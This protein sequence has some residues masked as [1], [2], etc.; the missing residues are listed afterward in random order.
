MRRRYAL[1][2]AVVMVALG[3][4][5]GATGV[6][7]ASTFSDVPA[8]YIFHDD[9][10]RL[11]DLD[12]I[13]GFPDGTFKP[14]DPVTRQQFAKMIV[15]ST[16]KH[17][18]AVDN[19]TDP[20]FSD[21][22]PGMGV[23]YP[24]DYIE[25]A[26]G[27]EYIFGNLGAFN[28]ADNITRA[29]LAL[30][31]VRAGGDALAT[32]PADYE[33]GFTDLPEFAADAIATAKFNG[34][35]DGKTTTTFDPYGNGT[36]GQ[37]C[38]MLSRLL[39]KIGE[40]GLPQ[41]YKDANVLAGGAAYNQWWTTDAAGSGT[42]PTTT[43]E[44]D[45]YRC[46][47]CHAWD[48][49]GNAASY[50]NRTGKSTGTASRPDVAAVDLWASAATKTPQELFDLVK[51]VG[52]RAIDERENSHPDFSTNATDAQIW[53][54]VKFLRE[55]AIDPDLLYD[56][57][58]TG[59]PVYTDT[60]VDPPVVVKPTLVYSNI[61]ALGN[62]ANGQA[63]YAAKCASCHGVDGTTISLEDMSLGKFLRSKPN[64]TWFKIKF[65]NP[66]TG[67]NPGLVHATSDL[68]DLYRALANTTTFPDL[69]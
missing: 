8:D 41:A 45:Y 15:L 49:K 60:S 40:P 9:I 33:T 6:L 30:I 43:A 48:L 14:G 10:V 19:Q 12:I 50:A 5:M 36:R 42:Q 2:A 57:M 52:G 51:G 55:G 39:D 46:K 24:F 31:I 44:A 16:D 56:L 67:M 62:E 18:D 32:P 61:G 53:N 28:P 27:A 21:V 37:V 59:L 26:A 23:P 38:K 35:L 22:T 64:E 34:I 65:G 54:I 29:Q 68:Q 3:T 69:P 63:I 66:G 47:S 25:E 1:F 4:L 13:G 7:G 58:V 20:T 11:A 17:T